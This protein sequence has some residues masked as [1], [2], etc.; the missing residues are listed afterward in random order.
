MAGTTDLG[1]LASKDDNRPVQEQNT[2]MEYS[3]DDIVRKPNTVDLDE[4]NALVNTLQDAEV[5]DPTSTSLQSRDIPTSTLDIVSD[6]YQD[7][8]YVKPPGRDYIG[9]GVASHIKYNEPVNQDE[10]FN[11][12]NIAIYAAALY[13]IF[14]LPSVQ[15]NFS[16]LFPLGTTKMGEKNVFGYLVPSLI[17]GGAIYCS[18]YIVDYLSD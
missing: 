12:Y 8:T 14:Q 9:D 15:R 3:A 13:F 6:N 18:K 16:L 2:R 17:F 1:G 10:I 4:L 7:P 5:K 11:V